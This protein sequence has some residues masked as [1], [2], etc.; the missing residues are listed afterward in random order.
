[1]IVAIADDE[2]LRRHLLVALS[3]HLATLRRD[4]VPVPAGVAE[5]AD[6]L[7]NSGL[8]RPEA[9]NVRHGVAADAGSA[10]E[11]L[12]VD[13]RQAAER[14]GVSA[15]TVRRMVAAGELP[16]V[17]VGGCRRIRDSDLRAHIAAL[18]AV[19]QAAGD[20]NGQDSLPSPGETPLRL[21]PAA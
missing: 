15:R 8:R 16:V 9:A 18:Q 17:E 6:V 12:A 14:L 1:M 21:S 11:V 3:A 4:G 7:R 2:T 5:L 19:N 10:A 20:G 13:Y